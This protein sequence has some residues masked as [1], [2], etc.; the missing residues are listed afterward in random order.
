MNIGEVSKQLKLTKK[1]INL[2]EQKGLIAPNKDESGYRI[3]SNHEIVALQQIKLLRSL[4]FSISEINELLLKGN[5]QLFDQKLDDLKIK[6]YDLQKKIQ[7]LDLIKKDFIDYTISEK[8]NNY[9]ELLKNETK[10]EI[11]DKNLYVDFERIFLNIL[12]IANVL[13]FSLM[14][15]SWIANWILIFPLLPIWIACYVLLKYPQSRKYFYKL[16][17]KIKGE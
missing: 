14:D 15:M 2:Y 12:L 10:E 9:Q 5:Y 4:D 7:Y 1:A 13:T 3:Y 11:N 17:Q 6:E 8:I 16:Y